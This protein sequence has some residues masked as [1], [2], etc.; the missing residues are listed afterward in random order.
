MRSLPILAC[1]AVLPTQA[2]GQGV[3]F[4]P[5]ATEVCLEAITELDAR[6]GCIGTSATKCMDESSD[7]HTTVG[8]GD[9]L[10]HELRYW[11]ARLNTA[12][13]ALV[14]REK[15]VDAEMAKVGSAAPSVFEPLRAMQ[16]AWITFRDEACT[17]ERAQWGGGSGGGPAAAMCLMQMTGEQALA[18]ETR[19]AD[20]G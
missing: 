17:Y 6:H 15:A 3:L 14:V 7:G 9:C 1:L 2:A 11:D 12:Y 16:R 10:R 20:R 18:L 8:M 13:S 19:L 4:S 5:D